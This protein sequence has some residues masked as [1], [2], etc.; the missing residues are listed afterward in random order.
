M[1]DVIQEDYIL[2]LSNSSSVGKT[3]DLACLVKFRWSSDSP[4]TNFYYYGHVVKVR[5]QATIRRPSQRWEEVFNKEELNFGWDEWEP[6]HCL[7]SVGTIVKLYKFTSSPELTTWLESATVNNI[8]HKT[9]K[10]TKQKSVVLFFAFLMYIFPDKMYYLLF[11]C[12]SVL[13][14]AAPNTEIEF[15]NDDG[16]FRPW[17]LLKR[18][19]IAGLGLFAARDFTSDQPITKYLGETTDEEKTMHEWCNETW[20]CEYICK[21]GNNWVAPRLATTGKD[22][23]EELLVAHYMNH[24]E[25]P[26]CFVDKATGVVYTRHDIKRGAELTFNY[27]NS[28]SRKY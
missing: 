19:T 12:C 25:S 23:L 27:N 21:I 20:R 11:I 26:N 17:F 7:V 14:F 18:S 4:T 13:L 10:T 1:S 5:G 3:G 2:T 15:I 28:N 22:R 9:R 6:D 16:I 8:E 24:S